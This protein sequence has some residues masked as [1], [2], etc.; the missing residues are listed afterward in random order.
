MLEVFFSR[1]G[2]YAR[3][4]LLQKESPFLWRAFVTYFQC[5]RWGRS[6]TVSINGLKGDTQTNNRDLLQLLKSSTMTLGAILTRS[7]R[8]E[9]FIF[10]LRMVI[11]PQRANI[12]K[13][14]VSTL[15]KGKTCIGDFGNYISIL[16]RDFNYKSVSCRC[17]NYGEKLVRNTGKLGSWKWRWRKK[18]VTKEV[19]GGEKKVLHSKCPRRKKRFVREEDRL[20]T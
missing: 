12:E 5:P 16:S 11:T 18:G 13:D 15:K 8:N 3:C 7:W 10:Y 1:L 19:I 6:L 14:K 4:F 17:Q 2:V 9:F 20:R